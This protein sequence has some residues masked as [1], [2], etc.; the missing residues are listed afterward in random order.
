METKTKISIYWILL[1]ICMILHTQFSSM[2]LFFGQSVAMPDAPGEIPGNMYYF[3]VVTMVLPF[4]FSFIELNLSAKWFTW[5]SLIWGALLILLNLFHF[6]ETMFV[7]HAH[8]DQGV[9]L[10]F[11]PV[12]NVMLVLTLIRSLKSK[13]NTA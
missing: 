11:V 2:G 5:V 3:L 12:V 1:G 4:I 10:L 7:E 13:K 8:V 6:Y 9:L